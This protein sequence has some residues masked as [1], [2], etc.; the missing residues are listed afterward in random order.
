MGDSPSYHQTSYGHYSQP[1]PS[2]GPHSQA[3]SSFDNYSPAQASQQQSY[4][5]PAP[6]QP[7]QPSNGQPPSLVHRRYHPSRPERSPFE[8]VKILDL[9]KK[10]V[11]EVSK[12][13]EAQTVLMSKLILIEIV[14]AAEQMGFTVACMAPTGIAT[15]TPG[16]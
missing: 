12:Y 1:P 16:H 6:A 9:L 10:I 15:S 3:P 4:S 14:N 13:Q 11:K 5:Q 7:S 2:F 8:E